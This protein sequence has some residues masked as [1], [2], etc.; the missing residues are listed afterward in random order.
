MHN[1]KRLF[2]IFLKLL[3]SFS[4]LPVDLENYWIQMKWSTEKL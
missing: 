4:C 2:I 1:K 3:K